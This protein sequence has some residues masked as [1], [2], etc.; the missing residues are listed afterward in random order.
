MKL[1]EVLHK[2]ATMEGPAS[3]WK[4]VVTFP[5]GGSFDLGLALERPLWVIQGRVPYDDEDT[6]LVLQ[7]RDSGTAFDMFLRHMLALG[8]HEEIPCAEGADPESGVY[9]INEAG[10]FLGLA[11]QKE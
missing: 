4:G 5:D 1:A 10:P 8:D 11:E 6:L 9:V 2:L 7:A 3:V